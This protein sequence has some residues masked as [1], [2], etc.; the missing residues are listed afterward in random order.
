MCVCEGIYGGLRRGR[1]NKF[2]FGVERFISLELFWGFV[3]FFSLNFFV[4]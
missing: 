1:L 3:F 4:F 2:F